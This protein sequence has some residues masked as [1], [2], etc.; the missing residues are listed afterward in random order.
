V[1]TA[2]DHYCGGFVALCAYPH[3]NRLP[4]QCTQRSFAQLTGVAV[5]EV[6]TRRRYQSSYTIYIHNKAFLYSSS[7]VIDISLPFLENKVFSPV[8]P[9]PCDA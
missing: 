2:A 8:V 7:L 9:L 4:R 3:G 6:V 1:E 5:R